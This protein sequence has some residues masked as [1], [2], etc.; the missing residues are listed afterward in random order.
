MKI[1]RT[2]DAFYEK[3]DPKSPPKEVFLQIANLIDDY[4]NKILDSITIV[5]FGCASGAFV[6]YLSSR[7][8]NDNIIG[9]ELLKTLIRSGKKNY[10]NIKIK[11]GSILEINSLPKSSVH[12]LTVLGVISIFDDL[13]SIINNLI[14]W[15]KPGWKLFIHGMFNPLDVDIFVKYRLS[16]NFDKKEYESGWNIVSQKTISN[17]LLSKNVKN[18]KFH[19]F[20]ISIDLP[21]NLN[22][23]L[24]SW[25][26]K[27]EDGTRQIVN[28]TCLKQPQFILE[29][30]I[31]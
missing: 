19:D 20:K 1:V 28:G 27:M 5:D 31:K 15:I 26:E 23:P 14:H 22:D 16:E 3:I 11:Y 21:K 9:Y 12:V 13:D 8:P 17:L 10:P 25:T 18:I 2:H 29:A 7:Y 24:R 6:N 30:D 4:K